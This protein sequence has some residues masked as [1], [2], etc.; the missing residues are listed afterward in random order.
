MQFYTTS[1]PPTSAKRPSSAQI[2]RRKSIGFNGFIESV[3]DEN[4]GSYSRD[5]NARPS[6]MG[7]NS[8][9]TETPYAGT[10]DS[11]NEYSLDEIRREMEAVQEEFNMMGLSKRSDEGNES[12]KTTPRSERSAR[13]R[14]RSLASLL[15][16]PVSSASHMNTSRTDVSAISMSLEAKRERRKAE[17]DAVRIA[18][19]LMRLKWLEQDYQKRIDKAQKLAEMVQR[20]RDHRLQKLRRKDELRMERERKLRE[21]RQRYKLFKSDIR[22]SVKQSRHAVT[23]RKKK[24]VQ[25]VKEHVGLLKQRRKREEQ[26]IL[27]EKRKIIDRIEMQKR[28]AQQQRE[29]QMFEKMNNVQMGLKEQVTEE[30]RAMQDLQV[31]LQR[32][33]RY[34]TQ[35]LERLAVMEEKQKRVILELQTETEIPAEFVEEQ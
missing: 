11:K 7:K 5:G 35:L 10:T 9:R 28:V 8:S 19:R 24:V 1:R 6:M 34:E 15:L 18:N 29:L 4:H 17:D 23:E 20:N 32:M 30:N 12:S 26:S 3:V 31:K 22:Q 21:E 33:A 16:S 14:S 13:S 25:E 2:R 27:V